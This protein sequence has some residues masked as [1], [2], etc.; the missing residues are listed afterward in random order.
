MITWAQVEGL[1]PTQKIF[2]IDPFDGHY[3]SFCVETR[4]VVSAGLNGVFLFTDSGGTI[5]ID[6]ADME[7]R[8]AAFDASCDGL[9]KHFFVKEIDAKKRRN[10]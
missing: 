5:F 6:R 10:E 9:D 1:K 8:A 7:E 2:F 4:I 3:F